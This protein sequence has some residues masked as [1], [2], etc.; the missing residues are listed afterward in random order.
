MLSNGKPLEVLAL[1]NYAPLMAYLPLASRREVA[2][3]VARLTVSGAASISSA[4]EVDALL[5]FL[6]PLVKALI[7][8]GNIMYGQPA[9]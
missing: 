8:T 4:Q 5:S 7:D 2:T 3:L 6:Q 1:A 9:M